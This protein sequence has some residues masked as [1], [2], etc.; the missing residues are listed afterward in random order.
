M[1]PQ[2][3]QEFYDVNNFNLSSLIF[4]LNSRKIYASLAGLLQVDLTKELVKIAAREIFINQTS[5]Y[6]TPTRP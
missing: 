1:D 3:T 2:A 4:F 5:G 6:I